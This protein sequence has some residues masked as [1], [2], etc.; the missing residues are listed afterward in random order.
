MGN[1]LCH[2]GGCWHNIWQQPAG[3][4]S[5]LDPRK[6]RGSASGAACSLLSILKAF[7]QEIYIVARA[8]GHKCTEANPAY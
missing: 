3:K 6:R 5:S 7:G 1:Q 2:N 4:P 8:L